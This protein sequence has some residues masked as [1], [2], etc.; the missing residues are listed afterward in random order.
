MA[1]QNWASGTGREP[2]FRLPG[3]TIAM[4]ATL[5]FIHL[6]LQ[7]MGVDYQAFA[8]FLLAFIPAR[9]NPPGPTAFPFVEGSQ[10]WSF[11]SHVLLHGGWTHVLMNCLWLVVFSAVVVRRLGTLRFLALAAV[12]AVGGATAM[13]V[14][15]W[16]EALYM[17]G[18]STSVSGILAASIPVMY[19]E[20]F[21]FGLA[22][23]AA[24]RR[25]RALPLTGIVKDRR[26][27]LFTLVWLG[28]TLLSGASFLTGT[29]LVGN[30]SIAWEAHLGG[31]LAGLLAFYL[32][33][34]PET[35]PAPPM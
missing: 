17:I 19:G 33:D 28:L 16:G 5:I 29:A 1:S 2:M 10:Y 9:F 14:S 24:V 34:R 11:L 18:A 35:L 4:V 31:F 20:G 15:H 30:Q 12:S 23:H 25:V 8:M 6:G 3:V 22:D 13:L 27:A 7:I 32:L 21:R 26:A